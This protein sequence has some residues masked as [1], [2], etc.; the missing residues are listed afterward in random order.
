MSAYDP[1]GNVSDPSSAVS[2]TTQPPDTIPPSVPTGLVAAAVSSTQIN[3]SWSESTDDVG[4]MG[5]KVFRDGAQIA[6][7][8]QLTYSDN[9]LTASTTYSYTVAAYDAAGNT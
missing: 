6:T 7:A 2:A 4:V 9:R 3:L 5:Y 1:S 8:S